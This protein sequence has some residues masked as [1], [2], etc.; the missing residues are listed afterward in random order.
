MARRREL[1]LGGP[2]GR[3]RGVPAT[4]LGQRWLQF[5]CNVGL[6]CACG[7]PAAVGGWVAEA[8][9]RA[10]RDTC[11]GAGAG[12]GLCV[13]N[14]PS[15]RTCIRQG[16]CD[17]RW[18][19]EGQL[20]GR[21]SGRVRAVRGIAGAVCAVQSAQAAGAGQAS[22]ARSG[23]G[24]SGRGDASA[25]P[26]TPRLDWVMKRGRSSAELSPGAP[27]HLLGADWR[28][29]CVLVGPMSCRQVAMA[30][31]PARARAT[32]GPLLMNSTRPAK[33]GLPWCSS[34]A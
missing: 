10:G 16:L 5:G 29:A 34:A 3:G 14:T 23:E 33:K 24:R 8:W 26:P 30:P 7:V 20:P 4:H 12:G 28:A 1:R 17:Q 27:D 2:G 13:W 19:E 32:R 18:E 31:G 25:P 22:E 11:G 21:R 15:L 6:R 9:S